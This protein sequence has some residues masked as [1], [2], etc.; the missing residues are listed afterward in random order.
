MYTEQ[1]DIHSN[2]HGSQSGVK[3]SHSQIDKT[4]GVDPV[5]HIS[6]HFSS[7]RLSKGVKVAHTQIP[8]ISSD[9]G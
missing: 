1:S 7:K 2:P 9:P 4:S 5:G 6:V 3:A 8:K